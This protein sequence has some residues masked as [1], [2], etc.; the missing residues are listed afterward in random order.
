MKKL[1]LII[2]L[3]LFSVNV[4]AGMTYQECLALNQ[5]AARE[6]SNVVLSCQGLP[7]SSLLG[8]TA[9]TC[10]QCNADNAL[11][12]KLGSNIVINCDSYCL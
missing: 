12:A 9:M 11:A 3:S 8:A 5:A 6:G 2:S 4:F 1:L 7:G 10:Q